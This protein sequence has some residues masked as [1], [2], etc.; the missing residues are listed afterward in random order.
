MHRTRRKPMP[1]RTYRIGIVVLRIETPSG[2]FVYNAHSMR[3]MGRYFANSDDAVKYITNYLKCDAYTYELGLE[4]NEPTE[5]LC[6]AASYAERSFGHHETSPWI[7][8]VS[9]QTITFTRS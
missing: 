8:V 3:Y 9:Q 7:E 4:L 6:R 1:P 2:G 5:S